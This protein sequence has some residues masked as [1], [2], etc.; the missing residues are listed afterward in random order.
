MNPWIVILLLAAAVVFGLDYLL[1]R[2]KWNDNS[3]QEKISLLVNMFSVGPYAFLSVFGILWGIVPS[4]PKTDFGQVVTDVTLAMG[5]VYFV[6][7]AVAV[8]LSFILR[9]KGKIKAS[10]WTNIIAFAY[11]AIVMAVNSIA[12]NIL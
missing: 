6:V 3:K 11:I 8:I 9:K 2:K 12:G 10:I 1:R 5:G 4:S 7:A